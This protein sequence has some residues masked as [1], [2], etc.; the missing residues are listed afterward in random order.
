MP[1]SQHDK[2]YSRKGA[3][4]KFMS[5]A[6]ERS[7]DHI[8][9]KDVAITSKDIKKDDYLKASNDAL[10]AKY[11]PV[12]VIVNEQLD[13][14]QFRGSTGAYLEAPPGKV[15]HNVLKMAREG[16]SFELRSALHKAST[17]GLTVRKEGVSFNKGQSKVDIEV[18][19]LQNTIEVYYM[20]L[21]ENT[22]MFEEN[23]GRTEV[24]ANDQT[25]LQSNQIEQLEKELSQSR[26]DMRGITEDQE[27]ANEELQSANEELLSSSEEL[28]TLNEELETT[29][30]EIQSTNEELTILNQELIER[31]EQLIHTR[32]YAEAIVATIHEPL[33]ILTS[34]FYIK[35]ANKCFY[36]TFGATEQHTE[37][38]AFFEWGNKIFDI[39]DLKEKLEKVLPKQSYFEGFEI[40]VSSLFL[41]EKVF[42]LNA[43]Q[44]I[45]ETSYE[46]LILL[47]M[48][49]ITERKS[50][51]KKQEEFKEHLELMVRNRTMELNEANAT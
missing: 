39:P 11:A 26:E 23:E 17:T 47:T 42:V 7:E 32:K 45:N 46:K 49:D 15:S 14:V 37:G 50:L 1:L 40:M 41:N 2:I 33:V 22:K 48:Q 25:S 28:Q 21:F 8:R 27:A 30:E 19:P 9:K 12:G 51:E 43:R 16:L 35:S 10:L 24:G 20:V 29:K 13:I 31:N 34:T 44:I 36:D 4:G 6:T 3:A 18:I 38:K 5:V